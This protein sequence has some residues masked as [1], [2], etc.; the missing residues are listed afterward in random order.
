MR[1]LLH[2]LLVSTALA[3]AF[4]ATRAHASEIKPATARDIGEVVD[5]GS[6][7]G[8]MWTFSEW[9]RRPEER[10]RRLRMRLLEVDLRANE[11]KKRILFLESLLQG[12][13]Y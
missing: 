12:N 2:L 9:L 6:L 11:E 3:L 5:P 7:P 8:A 13:A 1:R 4:F 10:V